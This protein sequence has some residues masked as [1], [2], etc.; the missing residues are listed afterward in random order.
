MNRKLILLLVPVLLVSCKQEFLERTP[1]VG[2]TEA[3]FYK[4][5]EDALAATIAC[6]NTLQQ[7]VTNIQG[8]SGLKPHF[9]WYFGDICSDDSDKG[10]SGDGDDPQLYDFERFQG[11]SAG[12]MLLVE[13]Q[14]AYRGIAYCNLALQKIPDIDM[15]AEVKDAYLGEARF[16]RAYWYFNLVTTFGGVPLVTTPLAST[17]YQQPRATAD[18]IWDLIKEDL[19][20]AIEFLPPRS[21]YSLNELGRAT[22]GS[23]QGLMTKVNAYLG[24]W[25]SC[26]A[27]SGDLINEG[28]YSLDAYGNI[29]TELGENGPGSIWEI[30]YMNASGGNWGQ[31]LEGTF[32]NVFQRARGQFNGYGFNL[33]TQDLVDEFE[34]GDPRLS[35]SLFQVGDVMGDRGV[36]TLDATGFPHLYYPKKNFNNAAE[37]APFGDPNPNGHT[38]DRVIRLSDIMLFHAEA[39]VNTGRTEEA[40]NMV[41]AVRDRA[42]GETWCP[43]TPVGVAPCSSLPLYGEWV[44]P[45]GGGQPSQ[46]PDV[47]V[48]DIW[49]ER[50]VELALEGHRFFDL[51]R[52]GRAADV[53]QA[54]LDEHFPDAGYSFVAGVNE[55]FPIPSNEITLSGGLII[56]NPG[57]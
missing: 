31:Q 15:D 45:A 38:N 32:T 50:R 5:P 44:T 11:N 25:E 36:F 10:G 30:Q 12:Q 21:A 52:Q 14:V 55:L 28:E 29:F 56:Q 18:Q 48:E 16:I 49:H 40:N 53:M 19:E 13:W 9:R 24:E 2:A 27:V 26:Y 6:Y 42:R 34:V 46:T 8:S 17:E 57:Y 22:R 33:P 43:E 54:H 51:V 47:T 35:H 20:F 7:E 37:E 4:T 3:N 1:V 23:A 41:N 39:C